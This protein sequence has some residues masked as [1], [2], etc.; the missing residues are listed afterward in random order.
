MPISFLEQQTLDV[1]LKARLLVREFA[2]LRYGI[3]K[4]S[5]FR[6][7]FMYPP[8]ASL[9][10]VPQARAT[11]KPPSNSNNRSSSTPQFALILDNTMS[12]SSSGVDPPT[13]NQTEA[14]LA[15]SGDSSSLIR[16]FDQHWR[17]CNFD[18]APSSGLPTQNSINC[19]PYLTKT[20]PTNSN[21]A[22]QQQQQ[23]QRAPLSFNLMSADP[24][25]YADS[26]TAGDNRK[27]E[28]DGQVLEPIEWR[29]LAA[30]DA[31]KWHF[32]GQ[33]FVAPANSLLATSDPSS[34]SS[35]SFGSLPTASEQVKVQQRS[36]QQQQLH[37]FVHN[38]LAT[39]KQ[40][41]MCNERSA[42]EVIKSSDDFRRTPFR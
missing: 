18:T 17:E 1:R 33:N 29:D 30:N 35:L 25:S 31:A 42:L 41:V 38:Q 21:A 13:L 22:D 4:E 9:P 15:I 10:G 26:Q 12:S 7:D 39:N 5:G 6:S 24:F 28:L 23:Q 2:S 37:S 14:G 27:H 32:C 34:S 8:F 40:N 3:F 20:T 11:L 36:Q 16:G 19:A